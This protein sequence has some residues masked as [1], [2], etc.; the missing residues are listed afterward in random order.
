MRLGQFLFTILIALILFA[1]IGIVDWN[2]VGNWALIML[3]IALMGPVL[4]IISYLVLKVKDN[5]ETI[6][7]KLGVFFNWVIIISGFVIFILIVSS[8]TQTN[9]IYHVT[10]STAGDQSKASK[11]NSDKTIDLERPAEPE[12]KSQDNNPMQVQKGY[13]I[14]LFSGWKQDGSHR[15][16]WLVKELR[17]NIGNLGYEISCIEGYDKT[18]LGETEQ[19]N[20]NRNPHPKNSPFLKTNDC[21]KSSEVLIGPFEGERMAKDFFT[22]Y[23]LDEMDLHLYETYYLCTTKC[24]EIKPDYWNDFYN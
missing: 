9:N 15:H 2:T 13:Y 14:S 22:E 8:I 21:D 12:S 4:L 24:E 7:R 23:S 6:N 16:A 3:A 5:S 17:K 18:Q 19:R 10:Q 20:R 1:L 11:S